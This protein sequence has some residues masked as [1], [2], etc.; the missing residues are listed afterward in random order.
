MTTQS[1]S[2]SVADER[3]FRPQRLDEFIGQG[4]L[5]KTLRLML[6]S[7]RQRCA[8]LEHLAFYGG[9]GLGKTTL[10]AIIAA[11]QNARFHEA[12]APAIQKPGDLAALLTML[13]PGDV[14]FLDEC[15]AL[16]RESAELLYS[17]ME[18]FKVSIKPDQS[19]RPITLTLHP[20][21]LVGATTDFGLLPEPMRARFGQT[22]FLQPYTLE[23]LKAV[24]LRAADTLAYLT[25]EPALDGIAV[26]AR[27]TPRV[28]LR[29]LRRC[30]D[31]AVGQGTDAITGELVEAT[32]P[33]LGL[34]ELGLEDA[35]RKYLAT[36][37]VTYRGGPVGPRSIA[38]NAGLDL[39]TVEKVIEPALLL[40]GLIARTPRGRRVTR[41]G[42]AHA[43]GFIAV[44]SVNW[45]RVEGAD[46]A[47][48]EAEEQ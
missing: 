32:M 38:A 22:F 8:T 36:L 6:A 12:A 17:A 4:D 28:A 2:A 35:D 25:D 16:R 13:Q 7:A 18:D 41:K 43:Q 1:I 24:V 47:L 37:I 14:L 23:E 34:D 31:A 9:P 48:P 42:Y 21:T 30:V 15:H 29:L 39:A 20:F 3:N 27:G 46:S 45:N 40:M 11:E 19:E 26:R 44:P 10:A 5:K 33:I